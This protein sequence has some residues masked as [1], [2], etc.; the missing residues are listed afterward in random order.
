MH[1][2]SVRNAGGPPGA[3]S[4]TCHL[5]QHGP[6]LLTSP[7]QETGRETPSGQSLLHRNGL[8][9][10]GCVRAAAQVSRPKR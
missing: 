5:P 7:S 6:C 2:V 10:Q 8:R 9:R 3:K 4:G 1:R